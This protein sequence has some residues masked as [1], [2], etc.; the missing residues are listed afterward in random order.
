[1]A[2]KPWVSGVLPGDFILGLFAPL[3][4]HPVAWVTDDFNDA[5]PGLAGVHAGIGLGLVTAEDVGEVV[6]QE[7]VGSKCFQQFRLGFGDFG[8]VWFVRVHRRPILH[9]GKKGPEPN[10]VFSNP[11][12][13]I[14]PVFRKQA[15]SGGTL[16]SRCWP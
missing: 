13:K 12:K 5:H 6:R 10:S 8:C 9:T 1:M 14:T 15:I 4:E 16:R 11:P 3:G 7:G 2:D